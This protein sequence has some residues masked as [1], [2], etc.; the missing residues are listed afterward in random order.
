[1][2][3]AICNI[4]S[5]SLINNYGQTKYCN[6]IMERVWQSELYK[7]ISK[8]LPDGVYISNEVGKVFTNDGIVDLY[9]PSY[10]WAVELLIDGIGLNKSS[11][12][13]E[14]FLNFFISN[15]L[16]LG[17][18]YRNIPIKSYLLIDIRQT[19]KARKLYPNT[20]FITPSENYRT[21]NI[22]EIYIKEYNTFDLVVHDNNGRCI[23]NENILKINETLID[24]KENQKFLYKIIVLLLISFII[25]K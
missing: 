13:L 25:S 8:C 2:A 7:S 9:I 21:F 5:N 18:K 3:E 12:N 16:S 10:K 14:Y 22:V 15:S 23:C 11:R 20:W 6:K 24:I 19:V 4:D 1:M 17:G